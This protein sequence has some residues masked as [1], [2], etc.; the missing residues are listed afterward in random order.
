MQQKTPP[1]ETPDWTEEQI[2]LAQLAEELR[3]QGKLEN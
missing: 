1:Q 2:E 3:D